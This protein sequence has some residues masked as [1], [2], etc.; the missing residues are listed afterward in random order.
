[1]ML[2]RTETRKHGDEVANL[3]PVLSSLFQ[4]IALYKRYRLWHTSNLHSFSNLR[5]TLNILL[6]LPTAHRLAAGDR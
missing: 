1:M 5:C 4:W 3:S 6:M 2:T